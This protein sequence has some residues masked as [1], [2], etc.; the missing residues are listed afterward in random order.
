VLQTQSIPSSLFKTQI[1]FAEAHS[2]YSSLAA[3]DFAVAMTFVLK[4]WAPCNSLHFMKKKY[5]II[6]AVK[7]MKNC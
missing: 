5:K 6:T 4:K 1:I 7:L 2:I 3:K